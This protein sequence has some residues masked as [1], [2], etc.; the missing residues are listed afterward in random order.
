[1]CTAVDVDA[2][3]VNVPITPRVQLYNGRTPI[4]I[5]R[6]YITRDTDQTCDYCNTQHGLE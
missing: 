6:S 5:L 4:Y 3:Q 2:Q 1:M